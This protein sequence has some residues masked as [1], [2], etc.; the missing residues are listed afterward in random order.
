MTD[1]HWM[2][3]DLPIGSIERFVEGCW[4]T[5]KTVASIY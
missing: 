4:L 5:S 2:F 3:D 1:T